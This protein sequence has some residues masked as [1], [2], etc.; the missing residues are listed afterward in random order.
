MEIKLLGRTIPVRFT[1]DREL[2][3]MAG[4]VDV[5]GFYD[6]NTIHLS[7]SLDAERAK[8][9]LCHEIAHAVLTITGQ[10]NYMKNKKEEAICDA[11]E[12]MLDVFRSPEVCNYLSREEEE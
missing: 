11:F 5:I 1:A 10:H 9:T 4:G 7:S 3:S 8:R 6:G 2:N 12:A